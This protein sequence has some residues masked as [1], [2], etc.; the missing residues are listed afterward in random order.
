MKASGHR[1]G[2]QQACCLGHQQHY[3]DHAVDRAVCNSAQEAPQGMQ[4]MGLGGGTLNFAI[5]QGGNSGALLQCLLRV[6]FLPP[7]TPIVL[8]PLCLQ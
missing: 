3:R 6:R 7:C 4:G 2:Q 1:G 8:K 5:W